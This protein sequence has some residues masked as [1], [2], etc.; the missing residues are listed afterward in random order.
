MAGYR[1]SRC[2]Y[3][4]INVKAKCAPNA[5]GCRM[6]YLATLRAMPDGRG[7]ASDSYSRTKPTDDADGPP[8]LQTRLGLYGGRLVM[9]IGHWGFQTQARGHFEYVTIYSVRIFIL[10][11]CCLDVVQIFSGNGFLKPL[12]SWIRS[13]GE[14]ILFGIIT[15]ATA[16]PP[17]AFVPVFQYEMMSDS[18]GIPSSSSSSSFWVP[19]GCAL[20]TCLMRC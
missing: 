13:H 18:L 4:C 5:K 3:S 15:R 9:C 1:I 11:S 17:A 7:M 14:L 12:S 6:R 10:A 16:D 19:W 20:F 8:D 2:Q